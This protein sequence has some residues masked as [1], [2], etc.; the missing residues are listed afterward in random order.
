MK[1]Q[2][3]LFF[4]L[5]LLAGGGL[6]AQ[7][8]SEIIVSGRLGGAK[9]RS[10]LYLYEID[11]NGFLLLDSTELKKNGKFEFK[12][13]SE[14]HL[15]LVIR[16]E[17]NKIIKIIAAPGENITVN[18][19]YEHLSDDYSVKGSPDTEI[20]KKID[21][22]VANTSVKLQNLM[23]ATGKTYNQDSLK[24][25]V[26]KTQYEL[27]RFLENVIQQHFVSLA[28]LTA[29]N[30]SLMNAPLFSFENDF[31]LYRCLA[32]SLIRYYPQNKHAR[33]FYDNVQGFIRFK[34]QFEAT[35]SRAAIRT[36]APEII[37]LDKDSNKVYLSSLKN[38][39]ILLRF[40]N[41]ACDVCREENKTLKALYKKFHDKG[42]EIYA[43]SIGTKREEWL[44]VIEED[45]IGDWINVKIPE[46]GDNIPNMGSYYVWLYGVKSVP[47]SLL[48]GKDGIITHKGF[49]P[50]SLQDLLSSILY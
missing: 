7:Q 49:K 10:K 23:A 30:Q 25:E 43:V 48:I 47:F 40:W 32:D 36:R 15:F 41:P 38:K 11:I 42:F 44:Y 35:E 16:T 20:I 50:E 34:D 18:G 45:S 5:T 26:A 8:T 28:A 6:Y 37:L 33:A 1:A 31:P 29:I 14:Q 27:K 12:T 13:V 9:P 22:E 24:A 17:Q 46:E 39:V 4:L 2:K 3:I 21:K 19:N